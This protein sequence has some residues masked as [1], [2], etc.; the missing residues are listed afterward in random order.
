MLGQVF[1][2]I[3]V[4]VYFYALYDHLSFRRLCLN[5]VVWK[6]ELEYILYTFNKTMIMN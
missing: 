5:F 1:P 2:Y 6:F 3:I 4:R